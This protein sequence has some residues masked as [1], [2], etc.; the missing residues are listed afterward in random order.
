MK[1][2]ENGE[3]KRYE[4]KVDDVEKG[5][6]EIRDKLKVTGEIKTKWREEWRRLRRNEETTKR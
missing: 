4:E 3:E 5:K 1:D 2:E 6:G